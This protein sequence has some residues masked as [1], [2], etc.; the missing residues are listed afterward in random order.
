M[1]V[2]KEVKKNIA[3]DWHNAFPQLTQFSET[4][5][6]K[7]TGPLIVGLELTRLRWSEEYRPHFVAYPL[8]EKDVKASLDTPIVLTEYYDRKGL[9]YFIPYADHDA[10]FPDMVESVRS[11]VKIPFDGDVSAAGINSFIEAHANKFPM[12]AAPRSYLQAKLHE[13][14]FNIADYARSAQA[15]VLLDEIRRK[16]RDVNHFTDFGVNI[17]QWMAK[18]ENR[19][20]DRAS[21]LQQIAA[22]KQDKKLSKLNRSEL[23]D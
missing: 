2:S 23:V 5:L 19:F 16:P 1:A 17:D 3:N 14:K 15:G 6:Y 22:N 12:N 21:F 10:L 11:Q 13:V 9:Q 7:I 18:L 20:D 8:W 4:K